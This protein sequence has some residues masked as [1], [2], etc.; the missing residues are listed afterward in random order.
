MNIITDTLPE[1]I[2][3]DGDIY[4]LKTDFKVWLKFYD[5]VRDS[6]KSVSEKI[7]EAVLC[8]FDSAK[9]KKLPDTAE[10]TL[11]LL[12]RFFTEFKE[13]G[14]SKYDGKRCFDLSED[15]KYIYAAFLQEYGIDL[16]SCKM[17][18]FKFIALLDALTDKTQ[19]KRIVAIRSV[20]LAEIGDKKRRDYYRRLKSF[21]ELQGGPALSE[22]DIAGSLEKAF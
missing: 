8:C 4:S 3:F 15:S 2:Y 5:I 18:W 20:D 10:K 17:H 21:Y 13:N 11:E 16:T 12:M 9:C 14:D 1:Q 7:T 6:R 22:K 19:L